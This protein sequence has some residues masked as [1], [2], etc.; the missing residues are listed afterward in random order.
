MQTQ[1]LFL[2]SRINPFASQISDSSM[3]LHF[4]AGKFWGRSSSDRL[5]ERVNLI[6]GCSFISQACTIRAP[7]PRLIFESLGFS[8]SAVWLMH[9]FQ[10][11]QHI[12]CKAALYRLSDCLWD[13]S[14]N[15]LSNVTSNISLQFRQGKFFWLSVS[16]FFAFWSSFSARS[17]HC[18]LL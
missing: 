3:N 15:C 2:V 18:I 11:G 17:L 10:A 1:I 14:P 16:S 5:I 4:L 13:K 7:P 12:F 9:P 6:I 8:T